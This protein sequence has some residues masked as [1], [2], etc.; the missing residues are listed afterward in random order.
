[1]QTDPIA[2]LLTRIRNASVARHETLKVPYSKIKEKIARVLADEGFIADVRVIKMPNT[3]KKDIE[4]EL[5]YGPN[6]EPVIRGLKRVSRPGL[7][8]Y[9]NHQKIPR[10]LNGLGIA[11]LSTSKGIKSGEVSRRE[12]LGGEYLCCVW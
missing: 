5:K 3:V 4:I 8:V 7:R 9:V 2:D 10:I 6:N 12:S 11:V 1:M